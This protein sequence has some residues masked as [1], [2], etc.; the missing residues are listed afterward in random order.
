M[1]EYDWFQLDESYWQS[2][3]RRRPEDVRRCSGADYDPV[4]R[5]Y[6]IKVL[7]R[8]VMVFPDK[9]KVIC[10]FSDGEAE[11]DFE[12]ALVVMTQLVLDKYIPL[13]GRWVTEKELPGGEMFFR[14]VHS[15]PIG[16]AL[17]RFGTDPHAFLKAGLALG[18][19]K[20]EHGDSSFILYVLPFVPVGFVLWAQDEEFP[21]HLTVLFDESIK[22]RMDL[23][24]IWAVVD[25]TVRRLV[26][27]SHGL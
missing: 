22:Q 4:L 15:L 13:S 5:A 16:P 10:C 1:A 12:T 25:I 3:K 2:L 20:E 14:G 24:T 9:E 7:D 19:G 23:D 17:E 26:E 21:A 8:S 11:V 27:I 18:G 6:E